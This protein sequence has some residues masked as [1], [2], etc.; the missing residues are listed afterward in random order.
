MG[1]DSTARWLGQR[2]LSTAVAAEFAS[3]KPR[4]ETTGREETIASLKNC[5]MHACAG[6]GTEMRARLGNE[7][8]ERQREESRLCAHRAKALFCNLG[9]APQ[10]TSKCHGVVHA[11]RE[12]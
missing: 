7:H 3:S 4:G 10:C 11:D 12:D 9:L 5:E 8:G 6:I 2:D 1:P